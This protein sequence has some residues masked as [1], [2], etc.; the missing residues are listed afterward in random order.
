MLVDKGFKF[1]LYPTAEQQQVMLQ[2][3]G[4]CR[5]VYNHFLAQAQED[6]KNGLKL[7]ST[8]DFQKDLTLLKKQPEFAWLSQSDSQALNGAIANLGVA[9]ARFFRGLGRYPQFKRKSNQQSYTTYCTNSKCLSI[10]DNRIY[11]PKVGWVKIKQHRKLD[12]RTTSGTVTRTCS[13]KYFIS[14][15]CRDCSVEEMPK[16][17]SEIGLDLGIQSLITT[18]SGTRI[19]SPLHL[20][21]AIDKLKIEQQRLSAK[22]VGSNNWQKQRIKVAR[23]HERVAN[24]RKQFLHQ[25][26]HDIIKNHDFIAAEDLDIQGMLESDLEDLSKQQLKSFHRNITDVSW[27][28]LLRQFTYKAQWYGKQFVQVDRYFSSSQLCS[29]CG[30]KNPVVKDLKVRKWTCPNCGSTHDRDHNAAINI[31]AE[32]RKLVLLT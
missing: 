1:R 12:G 23:A 16:T 30:Y 21:R 32:G 3:F 28:E 18:S 8:Y 26:S 29:N 17:G 31:L 4:S 27:G 14:L 9:Y 25:L 11:I 6:Y 22:R 20:R 5:F 10:E 13:G 15:H 19:Q 2:I 7:K 24:Q